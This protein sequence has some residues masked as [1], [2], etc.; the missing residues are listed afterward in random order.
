MSLNFYN[1]ELNLSCSNIATVFDNL[2]KGELLNGHIVTINNFLVKLPGSE[3]LQKWTE[4]SEIAQITNVQALKVSF[5]RV[6]RSAY[7]LSDKDDRRGKFLKSK[8]TLPICKVKERVV[9]AMDQPEANP[10]GK[11]ESEVENQHLVKELAH[12]ASILHVTVDEI[13]KEN[14][15]L[16][17]SLNERTKEVATLNTQ[18]KRFPPHRV[19]QKLM[20]KDNSI[21]KL[22][23]KIISLKKDSR[24]LS[25]LVPRLQTALERVR[26]LKVSSKRQKKNAFF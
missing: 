9:E 12:D 18:L 1:D 11:L 13:S 16:R 14:S 2:L 19:R 7:K 5:L 21:R 22:K 24:K 25:T 6:Q 20:R 3:S 4:L 26:K 15:R 17:R 23:E 10:S 8:Y